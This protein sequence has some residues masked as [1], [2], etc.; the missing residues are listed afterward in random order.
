MQFKKAQRQRFVQGLRSVLDQTDMFANIYVAEDCAPLFDGLVGRLEKADQEALATFVSD[1]P[2]Y[3]FVSEFLYNRLLSHHERHPLRTPLSAL[4]GLDLDAL[5]EEITVAIESLPWSYAFAIGVPI[6]GGL[7]KSFVWLLGDGVALVRG[8]KAAALFRKNMT[9][10]PQSKLLSLFPE[11]GQPPVHLLVGVQGFVNVHEGTR[12][13]FLGMDRLKAL[14]GLM[15][16]IRMVDYAPEWD[17]EEASVRIGICLRQP[18]GVYEH[19]ETGLFGRADSN[20]VTGL[21]NNLSPDLTS[22]ETWGKTV[23]SHISAI[24]RVMEADQATRD[25]ILLGAQWFFESQ[26]GD[27]DL[28]RF[29]QTMVCLEILVGEE[30]KGDQPKLGISELIRNRV[31][32]LIGRDMAER[33]HILETF[34]AIYKV[35]SEIV[36][37][38]QARLSKA[39]ADYHRTLREYCVRVIQAEIALLSAGDEWADDFWLDDLLNRAALDPM[40]DVFDPPIDLDAMFGAFSEDEA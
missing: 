38:G 4:S 27:N 12:P 8:A 20:T 19:V 3:Q 31:A 6:G 32:Y 15:M 34:G 36:H 22:P 11:T 24:R 28:L 9:P 21:I 29:V 17:R 25:R 1:R 23:G 26:S 18:D 16:A 10:P 37:R 2:L 40:T 33:N 13:Y 14:L 5:A 39:E 7:P 30:L 35:R